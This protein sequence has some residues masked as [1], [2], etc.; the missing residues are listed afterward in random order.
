MRFRRRNMSAQNSWMDSLNTESFV[1]AGKK[2]IWILMLSCRG[3]NESDHNIEK[4][5]YKGC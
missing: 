2:N 1:I 5:E 4:S 3:T